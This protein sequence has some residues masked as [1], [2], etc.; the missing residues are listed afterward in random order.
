M[1]ENDTQYKLTRH[2]ASQ[3]RKTLI[4]LYNLQL[5]GYTTLRSAEIAGVESQLAELNHE[6]KTYEA[7]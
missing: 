1:I 6:I 3:F 4:A 2:R 5:E 7:K